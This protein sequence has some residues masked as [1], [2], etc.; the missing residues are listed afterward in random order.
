MPGHG[1]CR[2]RKWSEQKGRQPNLILP[3]SCGQLLV[4]S[5]TKVFLM[6][7]CTK[8]Q[9]CTD[10]LSHIA[11]ILAL[12]IGGFWTYKVFVRTQVPALEY[13]GS[14]TSGLIWDE[15]AEK[16]LCWAAVTLDLKNEG[17]SSFEVSRNER[18]QL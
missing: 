5:A 14:L 10:T 7:I 17:V 4:S 9:A 13:R 11:Q 16:D 12:L 6:G 8:I 18:F 3:L 1:G 15:S 2:Q